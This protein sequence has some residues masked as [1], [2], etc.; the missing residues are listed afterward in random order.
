MKAITNLK[1]E[2]RMA[3]FPYFLALKSVILSAL[4]L[5]GILAPLQA[6]EIQYTR[7]S[8]WFGAAAGANFDYY[9]GSTQNLNKYLT[10]PTTFHE[11]DGVGLFIAPLVEFHRPHSVLG[12]ILQIGYDNR[13]GSFNQVITPCNCPA[14]LSANLTYLTVEPSLR[15]APFRS[16]FYLYGG[17]R[18]AFNVEK[19]F[20]Y[21]LGTNPNVI[22]QA[23]NPEVKGDFS[24][25]NN[26]LISM[27]VGAG[28]DI[29][30]SSKSKH[31]QYVLS[32]FVSFQPY[33]GQ[34]PRSTETWNITTLRV[35]AALKLGRGH[36]ILMP[37]AVIPVKAEVVIV[38]PEV[39]FVVNAPK[40]IPIERKVREIFPLRNYIFFDL[41]ST[42]I[43]DRYVLLKKNQVNDFK[44]DQLES[45]KPINLSGRSER[46]MIVYYNVLNILGDRMVKN[47]SVTIMLV[48]SSEKGPKDGREMAESVKQYLVSTFD[49][50]PSKI[51]I[52]GRNKPKIPSEHPG[53]QTD[54]VLL[55]EGDRR[56]SIESSSPVL[57]MEF[58]S[59]PDAPLRPVEIISMQE[60]PLDSYVS[61]NVQGANAAF[62]SWSLEIKD[63][64]GVVQYFGPYTDET[65][66]IPGKSILG[67]RPEGDYTVTM[68]GKTKS[69]NTVRKET[70]VHM[71]LWTPTTN[72][73]GMRFS[74]IFEFNESKAIAIYERYLTDIVTPR[75]PN[76][77][78][79]I[80]HG[81]TDI[82]G[83]EAYN[84]KLSVARANE[85]KSILENALS[86][87][88]RSDVKIEVYG[89]GEDLN[90]APFENKY[91]EQRFYNRTVIIDIIPTK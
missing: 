9:R 14:D 91:P 58:Q 10:V 20:S 52:E 32:P 33:Y 66:S 78:T 83:E 17:P 84:L 81:H 30:L 16:N 38:D 37:V 42:E 12:A 57:L 29:Q 73:E 31:T 24:N 55:R 65:M 3:W 79:V 23:A 60:A 74:V 69:G 7:P 15:L 67:T 22:G 2:S 36:K 11:G 89:F 43:P 19:T 72:E 77:A 56:V 68:I 28:Y 90:L 54:L 76:G 4:I 86:K 62:S 51:S 70:S 1:K 82:I 64:K 47:P 45:F 35:G 27:Q 85:V 71:V 34:S 41:E 8:W 80:I 39:Q 61:F 46:Q 59:G 87:A 53:G 75:I 25:V 48:G 21:Q 40:N 5:A 49:I 6:Q 26:T 13:K 50:A 18:L 63:D 44:E 88:G